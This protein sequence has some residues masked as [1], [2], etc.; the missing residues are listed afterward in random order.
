[1]INLSADKPAVFAE[2]CRLLRPGGRLGI[3]DVVAE[4]RLDA[5]ARADRGG[6]VEC[7]AGALSVAEYRAGLEAAGFTAVTLEFTHPV[8]DGLHASI[9]KAVKPTES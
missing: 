6:R 7:I 8:A 1:V 2:M 4:D 3:S 5:A 9:I